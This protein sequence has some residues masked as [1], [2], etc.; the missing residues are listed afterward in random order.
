MAILRFCFRL[1]GFAALPAAGLHRLRKALAIIPQDAVVFSGTVRRNLDPFNAATDDALWAALERVQL[2]GPVRAMGK[3]LQSPIAEYG[4]NL[5]VGQRQ[6]L[7]IA[8]AILRNPKILILDEATSSV[9][10]A[11]DTLIQTC[12]RDVFKDATIL[13]IAHR[14]NTI[15]DSDRVL[16]IDKGLKSEFDA[17]AALLE[18]GG[19]FANLHEAMVSSVENLG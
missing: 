11:T 13:T 15:M 10:S 19:L 6:L 7:C 18:A 3:G 17:P 1:E 2:A 5:S 12:V 14:L 8:R 4:A 9:D 16:I